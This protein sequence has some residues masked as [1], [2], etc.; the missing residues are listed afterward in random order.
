MDQQ[1]S[2]S[3]GSNS[4]TFNDFNTIRIRLDTQPLL[5]QVEFFLRGGRVITEQDTETGEVRTRFLRIGVPKANPDGIQSILNWISA[6]IN[7]QTVQG[8]FFVEHKTGISRKYEDY[9][10]EY[11]IE[12][13]TMVITNVYNWEINDDEIDGVVEF[14]MLL[15][16]PF[17]SRLIANKERDSYTETMKSQETNVMGGQQGGLK[18]FSSK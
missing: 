5:D 10:E 14:I 15:V 2:Q 13:A 8:N 12:L 4:R 9:I 3:T 11:H 7:P 6:T 16:I 1:I 17:M 18:M